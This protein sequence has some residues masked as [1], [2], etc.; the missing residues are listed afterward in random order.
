MVIDRSLKEGSGVS[1]TGPIK[2]LKGNT[3]CWE[4]KHL[5]ITVNLHTCQ[6]KSPW[7]HPRS[8]NTVVMVDPYLTN[9]AF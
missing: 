4:D 5:N 9:V 3:K 1:E 6:N 7:F 8:S 2:C